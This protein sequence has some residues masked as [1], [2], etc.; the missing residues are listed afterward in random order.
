[1]TNQYQFELSDVEMNKGRI[2]IL[3]GGFAGLTAATLIAHAG[4]SVTLVERSTEAGGREEHQYLM[5]FI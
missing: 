4:M 5:A 2:V 1:M 3:G